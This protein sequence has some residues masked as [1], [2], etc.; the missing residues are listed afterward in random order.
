MRAKHGFSSWERGRE[1]FP[2]SP[3]SPPSDLARAAATV[4]MYAI[5]RKPP[6]LPVVLTDD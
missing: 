3:S 4:Y 6:K 1:R 5:R 2:P